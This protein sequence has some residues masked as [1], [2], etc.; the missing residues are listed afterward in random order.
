MGGRVRWWNLLGIGLLSGSWFSTAVGEACRSKPVGV[1]D[2]V[3]VGLRI[4]HVS[5]AFNTRKNPSDG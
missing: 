1:S 2:T 4:K 3:A 5:L